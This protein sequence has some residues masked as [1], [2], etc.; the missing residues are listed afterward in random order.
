MVELQ[1]GDFVRIPR[2]VAHASLHAAAS[3]HLALLSRHPLPQVAK[4]D[5]VAQ[6]VDVQAIAQRRREI[7]A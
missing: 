1:P 5:R 4:T 2:G 7:A 3:M 6:P